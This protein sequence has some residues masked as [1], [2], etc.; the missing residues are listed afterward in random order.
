MPLFLLRIFMSVLGTNR[1]SNRNDKYWSTNGN[2]TATEGVVVA[3]KIQ[4]R[5]MRA[6]AGVHS[7]APHSSGCPTLMQ[8]TSCRCSCRQRAP[9]MST[10]WTKGRHRQIQNFA[11]ARSPSPPL[12]HAKTASARCSWISHSVTVHWLPTYLLFWHFQDVTLL[13]SLAHVGP[14]APTVPLALALSTLKKPEA[15]LW[16]LIRREFILGPS[17]TLKQ[18]QWSTIANWCSQMESAYLRTVVNKV[19]ARYVANMACVLAIGSALW[20]HQQLRHVCVECVARLMLRT[21]HQ[22]RWMCRQSVLKQEDQLTWNLTHTH[23]SNKHTR[24]ISAVGVNGLES[25]SSTRSVKLLWRLGTNV[26]S[27]SVTDTCRAHKGCSR[28]AVRWQ[29]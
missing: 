2:Y 26:A 14:S 13:A 1:G 15:L 4:C 28:G 24:G 7:C 9:T 18:R 23:P 25:P 27:L 21:R 16:A 29:S 5:M 20:L 22:T 11:D 8:W 17:V 10:K 12:S 6:K 3:A 19:I